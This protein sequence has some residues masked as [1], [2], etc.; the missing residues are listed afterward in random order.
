MARQF[1]RCKKIKMEAQFTF[2][3]EY[4]RVAKGLH[5]W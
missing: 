3:G 1:L 4:L 5:L 2:Y